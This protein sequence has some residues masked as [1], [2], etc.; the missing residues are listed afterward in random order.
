MEGLWG[1]QQPRLSCRTGG[2]AVPSPG[3]RCIGAG[4][5]FMP[6]HR[7]EDD[8]KVLGHSHWNDWL[9]RWWGAL[10]GTTLVVPKPLTIATGG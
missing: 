3:W 4:C 7:P 6:G 5:P 1:L 2:L 8:K 10:L 9:I